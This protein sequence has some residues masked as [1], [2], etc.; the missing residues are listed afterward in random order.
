[1]HYIIQERLYKEDEW[2]DLIRGLE[3]LDLPYEIVALKPDSDEIVFT[4]DR[5]DIFCFGALKMARISKK[6]DWNPGCIM[7]PNHDYKVYSKYYKDNLL[8]YDSEILKFGE[9]FRRNGKFFCRPTLDTKT[10]TGRA[11]T[12]DEWI[13]FRDKILKGEVKSTLTKDSD[14]QVCSIKNF[15]QKEFRFYIVDGMII[16]GSLYKEGSNVR[17]SSIID[18]GAT[19]F[20]SSMLE[21]YQVAEAFTMDVCLYNDEWKIMECGCLN[22]AGLYH[23]NIPMLLMA[24]EDKY[25]KI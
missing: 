9:D 15:I 19:D 20:C 23:A 16:T 21:I 24:I 11:F 2:D 8:N 3:R 5:K 4:T 1:M 12:M 6:Y 18:E 7:T 13:T 25:N 10:F 14:I 17:Y 22:C